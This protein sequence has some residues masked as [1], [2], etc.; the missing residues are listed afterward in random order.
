MV[1]YVWME[2]RIVFFT[3]EDLEDEF[4]EQTPASSDNDA[5]KWPNIFVNLPA[6]RWSLSR[7]TFLKPHLEAVFAQTFLLPRRTKFGDNRLRYV[8]G[9]LFDIY[10]HIGDVIRE[11]HHFPNDTTKST[12]NGCISRLPPCR[13]VPLSPK[14][15]VFPKRNGDH[16]VS[17][18]IGCRV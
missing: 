6:R 8:Y 14:R 17:L 18:I 1:L 5:L 7:K 16:I 12:P 2:Q 3:T 4:T 15:N 9:V 13:A 11:P 10:R